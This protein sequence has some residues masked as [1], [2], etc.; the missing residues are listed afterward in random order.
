MSEEKKNIIITDDSVNTSHHTKEMGNALASLAESNST[1]AIVSRAADKAAEMVSDLSEQYGDTP[2]P[3]GGKKSKRIKLPIPG[4]DK[5]KARQE[6]NRRAKLSVGG[7]TRGGGHKGPG[8]TPPSSRK[9]SPRPNRHSSK[10]LLK[11]D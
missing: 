4:L 3:L 1:Q 7:P 5:R 6:K 9:P 2:G 11:E 10:T 8:Q